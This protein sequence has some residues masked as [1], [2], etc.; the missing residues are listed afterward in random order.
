MAR[1]LKPGTL[2]VLRKTQVYLEK[3]FHPNGRTYYETSLGNEMPAGT[4]LVVLNNKPAG[5]MVR[6]RCVECSYG[7]EIVYIP[8]KDLYPI[9]GA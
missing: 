3:V 5:K 4:I 6:G 2:V 9:K 8:S 7:S 1:H